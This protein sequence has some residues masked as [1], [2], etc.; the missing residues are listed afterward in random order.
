MYWAT[1]PELLPATGYYDKMPIT[2]SAD[3]RGSMLASACQ[4]VLML[5]VEVR[6]GPRPVRQ[7][8]DGGVRESTPLQAAVDAGAET[9]IAIT[10]A[11][12]TNPADPA[13]LTKAVAI[14][15][16][17][18]DTLSED[19]GSNDYRF[20]RLYEQGNRY[21]QAVRSQLLAQGVAAGT[22]QAVFGQPGNPFGATA[23]TRLHEIRPATKLVEG[24]PGGLTFD[25]IA[26][27]GMMAKGFAQA[28]AYFEALPPGIPV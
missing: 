21:L 11:P 14:L 1:R 7:Y 9:I 8:V 10:M 12:Q 5:P 4:P 27:Q 23:V 26:M 6:P 22:V 25:P 17:T 15:E 28:K 16:R 3:L 2:S 13:E 18:L 24:G 20:A 19:V